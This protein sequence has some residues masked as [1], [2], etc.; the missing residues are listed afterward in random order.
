VKLSCLCLDDSDSIT[1]HNVTALASIV[2]DNLVNIAEKAQLCPTGVAD[3]LRRVIGH[4]YFPPEVRVALIASLQ[5]QQK[6][7]SMN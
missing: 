3:V 6:K 7:R 4:D 1:E 5:M 2:I